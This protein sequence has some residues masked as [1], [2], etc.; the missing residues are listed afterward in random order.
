MFLLFCILFNKCLYFSTLHG[1][2]L[3]GQTVACMSCKYFPSFCGVSFHFLDSVLLSIDI[4]NFDEDQFIFS[5]V[6][7]VYVIRPKN[8][9]PNPR[10]HRFT[11]NFLLRILQIYIYIHLTFRPLI[12][13]ELIFSRCE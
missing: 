7:H 2:I 12:L 4:F 9:L 11:T 5:V 3:S 13:F 1:W 8:S 6:S 10:S